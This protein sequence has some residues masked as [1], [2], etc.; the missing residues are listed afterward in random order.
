MSHCRDADRNL[1]IN[2]DPES[3]CYR[4]FN[5]ISTTAVIICATLEFHCLSIRTV[6]GTFLHGTFMLVSLV[7]LLNCGRVVCPAFI[8]QL[9]NQ[10]DTH[11]GRAWE[12][13]L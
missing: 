9:A 13:N 4:I 8:S 2:S 10:D 7:G 12:V 6:L 5:Q 3:E 1:E 11:S